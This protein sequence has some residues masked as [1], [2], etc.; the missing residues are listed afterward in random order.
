MTAQLLPNTD[1]LDVI[2]TVKLF[3][4]CGKEV[5]IECIFPCK[6]LLSIAEVNRNITSVSWENFTLEAR[7]QLVFYLRKYNVKEEKNWNE[8]T[9]FYKKEL[10]YFE[11]IVEAFIRNSQIDGI[12]QHDFNWIM[13]AMCMENYYFGINKNIPVLFRELLPTYLA[14]HIPCGWIGKGKVD[15]YTTPVN[16]SEGILL[17]Y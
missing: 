14:G 10:K 8:I 17:I 2:K 13:L 9:L 12:E 5:A 11:P 15:T 3:A 1:F 4:N 6:Q 7:N 16:L